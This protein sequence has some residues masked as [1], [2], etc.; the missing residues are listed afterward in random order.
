MMW[1]YILVAAWMVG[2]LVV[3]VMLDIRMGKIDKDYVARFEEACFNLRRIN[4][5]IKDMKT[6][7]ERLSLRQE[8]LRNSIKLIDSRTY[9]ASLDIVDSVESLSQQVKNVGDLGMK[10][11]LASEKTAEKVVDFVEKCKVKKPVEPPVFND[12]LR[13]NWA[14]L[15]STCG[16]NDSDSEVKL[17]TIEHADGSETEVYT[18]DFYLK[19]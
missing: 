16:V 9:E 18:T 17:A 15:A 10:S 4:N 1:A 11:C 3:M 8:E 6:E 2:L 5:S 13:E 7:L 19:N 12:I 14:E